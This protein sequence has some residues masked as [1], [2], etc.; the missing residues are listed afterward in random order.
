MFYL[1]SFNSCSRLATSLEIFS[2]P[3]ANSSRSTSS[4]GY[5]FPSESMKTISNFLLAINFH[6]FSIKYLFVH[7]SL[8]H[9]LYIVFQPRKSSLCV[10]KSIFYDG[11][12]GD[13]G[14]QGGIECYFTYSLDGGSLRK[15]GVGSDCKHFFPSFLSK[16]RGGEAR[17]QAGAK[18]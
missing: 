1:W 11:G 14:G 3:C 17:A 7:K 2:K 5:H 16:K 12:K 13:L 8:K 10:L 15:G 6:L 9:F 4:K 18:A